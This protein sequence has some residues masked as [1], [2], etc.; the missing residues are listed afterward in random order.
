MSKTFKT[1]SGCYV[2]AD[3]GKRTRDTGAGEGDVGLCAE[4]YEF[5]GLD[6]AINDGVAT[7][8]DKA[9]HAFLSAKIAK[10]AN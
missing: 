7:E 1:G 6:N 10:R 3:C 2:C 4:C 9:R 8:A 5:G